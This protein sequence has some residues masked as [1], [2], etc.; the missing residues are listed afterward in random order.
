MSIRLQVSLRQQLLYLHTDTGV[1]SYPVS[2]AL[3]GAGE[4]DGSGCTP[5]GRHYIR[6]CIGSGAPI[7]AVFVGR[8]LTGEVYTPELALRY[9]RRDW[10]LTRILWLCGLEP[11]FNRGGRVDTQRRYIYIHGT[12]DTEPMGVP[13]SHGCIRM[14]NDDLLEL[15]EQVSPGTEILIEE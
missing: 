6:A 1:R 7:G 15:Y 14:R 2:T 11:G 9:P 4:R 3:A 12:P 5:R 13:L 10:I 8:R